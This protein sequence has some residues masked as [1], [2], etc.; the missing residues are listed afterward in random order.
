MTLGTLT[1]TGSPTPTFV[2]RLVGHPVDVAATA[3][4]HQPLHDHVHAAL[5]VGA[6]DTAAVGPGG[7]WLSSPQ[8]PPT[9]PPSPASPGLPFDL[10][11]VAYTDCLEDACVEVPCHLEAGV[12]GLWSAVERATGQA[13]GQPGS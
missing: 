11:Q 2:E 3:L 4:G 12:I 9:L 13:L 8:P 6:P 5:A 1:I 7:E 10:S